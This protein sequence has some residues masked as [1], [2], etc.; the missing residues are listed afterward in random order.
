M[1]ISYQDIDPHGDTWIIALYPIDVFQNKDK[2]TINDGHDP[3]DG[4]S[5]SSSEAIN[6]DHQET[7]D[8][9]LDTILF[10]RKTELTLT[11]CRL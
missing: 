9:G 4:G 11:C 1:D 8:Q 2:L 7:S 10:L 3:D 6:P 5:G